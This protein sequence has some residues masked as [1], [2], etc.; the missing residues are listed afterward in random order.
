MRMFNSTKPNSSKSKRK[1]RTH[2]VVYPCLV[3]ETLV[4]VLN[5]YGVNASKGKVPRLW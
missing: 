2:V 3:L 1:T 4:L 5:R